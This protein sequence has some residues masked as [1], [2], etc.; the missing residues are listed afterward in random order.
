MPGQIIY[1][2]DDEIILEKVT[3]IKIKL[4]QFEVEIY[5]DIFYIIIL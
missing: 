3:Y 4:N 5:Y 1:P 2:E